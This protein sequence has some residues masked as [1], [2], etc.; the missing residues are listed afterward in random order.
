MNIGVPQGGV[1]SPLFFILYN[2]DIEG[3]TPRNIRSY[4]YADDIVICAKGENTSS[5]TTSLENSIN[6]VN[7]NLESIGLGISAHKT[8]SPNIQWQK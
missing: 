8:K 3:R 5:A 2:A 1:L 4:K 7:K 6:T